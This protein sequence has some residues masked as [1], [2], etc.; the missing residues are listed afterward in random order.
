MPR[1]VL[2]AALSALGPASEPAPLAQS[3]A[4]FVVLS[5]EKVGAGVI[6]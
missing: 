4:S 1:A 2:A 6:R 5:S 3:W